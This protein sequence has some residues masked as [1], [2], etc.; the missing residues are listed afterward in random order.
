M[1]WKT[2]HSRVT[3]CFFNLSSPVTTC[4]L[5][6]NNHFWVYSIISITIYAVLFFFFH[7]NKRDKRDDRV[8][9]DRLVSSLKEKS[10][11]KIRMNENQTRHLSPCHH[12]NTSFF[13]IIREMTGWQGDRLVWSHKEKSSTK[14]RM[15]ENQTRHL[16]PCHPIIISIC[17]NNWKNSINHWLH[18]GAISFQSW[19]RFVWVW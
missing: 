17:V 18:Y 5:T 19:R 2:K 15:N 11:T 6:L 1:Q 13:I 10:S 16:S 14:N 7:Y 9:G 12:I 4:H 8:T 3:G